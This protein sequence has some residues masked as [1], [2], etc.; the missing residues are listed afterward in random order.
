MSEDLAPDQK[1]RRFWPAVKR[2]VAEFGPERMA[3]SLAIA[4]IA[5]STLLTLVGPYVLGKATD[6]VFNGFL[7][8]QMQ[9]GQTKAQ[10]IAKLQADGDADR[11]AMLQTM[12]V[13]P[14]MGMDFDLIAR[15]LLLTAVIYVAAESLNWWAGWLGNRLV[16]RMM[17]RLRG[18]VETK[19]HRIPLGTIDKQQR[20]DILSRLSNDLDN[21]GQVLSQS[22]QQ[23]IGG[24][25]TVVG[26]LVVMFALSWQLALVALAVVPLSAIIIGLVGKRSQRQ[27]SAQWKSTGALNSLVE[28]SISGQQ[29]LQVYGATGRT[30]NDFDRANTAVY[31]ASL[32]AQYLAGSLMPAMQF[33]SNLVFVGIAV[34]G[35]WR[36]ATGSMTLGGVQAFIQYSRQFSQPLAQLGGLIT[37][38]Q[39]GAA[40]AERVFDLL[41]SPD[42]SED[43]SSH[44]QFRASTGLIEL[45]DVS[46]SY[47]PSTPLIEDLT[48]TAHPGSTVAIVGH[49]GAGKT[50]LV[51]LL[52]RFYEINGGQILFDGVDIRTLS[53]EQVRRPVGMVLQD[54][55]LFEGTIYDNIAYGREDATHADVMRAAK[56]AYVDRFV[57]HLPDGYDTVITETADN[58]SQGERQLITIARAFVSDP[59]VLIL[60][61]ATSSVDTR[62]EVL[63]QEAMNRL[64][65]GRTSFVIAHRLSTIR[66]ADVIVVM[67]AGHIVEQGSHE[68]LM[69]AS[70]AYATLYRSQYANAGAGSEAGRSDT[71]FGHGG[72]E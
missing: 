18:R 43:T 16:Q 67:D 24:I 39:S 17:Y 28:E 53:R 13:T 2:I 10:A 69:A 62:T 32:R 41:D 48:L 71:G 27:Y 20:G 19:I 22:L 50:T 23:L 11:A 4:G 14:G 21:V 6:A 54:A 7:S 29:M 12:Q 36:V 25:I 3:F 49:T 5:V 8:L 63:I 1:A 64:R 60:D 65:E 26:V 33:V 66:N 15:L 42:E 38:L 58:M 30:L 70:G 46:F 61:E 34:L 47:E 56:D 45:K 35:A 52:L 51:N 31:S 40:S 37:Q 55:W 59:L 72:S 68:E 57:H 9:G 44:P